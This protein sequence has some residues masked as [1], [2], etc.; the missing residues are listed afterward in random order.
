MA[1]DVAIGAYEMELHASLPDGTSD[2]VMF[3]I[4]ILDSTATPDCSYYPAGC[5]Y[6]YG[7]VTLA[8]SDTSL[9]A[10]TMDYFIKTSSLVIPFSSLDYTGTSE[11]ST[12]DVVWTMTVDVANTFINLD[13]DSDTKTATVET[14]STSDL[15]SYVITLSGTIE[16]KYAAVGSIKSID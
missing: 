11:C 15:G 12:S 9:P 4:T 5:K 8:D 3:A 7:T 6:T 14:S 13:P 2:Y 1:T 10:S 16:A